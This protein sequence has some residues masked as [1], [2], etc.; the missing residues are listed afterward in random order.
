MIH[1]EH[2]KRSADRNIK[3]KYFKVISR[4]AIAMHVVSQVTA[5][6]KMHECEHYRKMTFVDCYTDTTDD[7]LQMPRGFATNV[8]T[9]RK[10]RNAT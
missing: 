3:A 2:Q 9:E 10:K 6:E 4:G 1:H 8:L 5:R 7:F